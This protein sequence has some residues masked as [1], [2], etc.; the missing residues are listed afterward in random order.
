MKNLF[1]EALLGTVD[2]CIASL[3]RFRSQLF[4]LKLAEQP[5][6]D[7][8]PAKDQLLSTQEIAQYLNC[9]LRTVRRLR[10]E[11]IIP[12]VKINGKW[13]CKLE[14]LHQAVENNPSIS[15]H[16]APPYKPEKKG[17]LLFN[18]SI[19]I[20]S[21]FGNWAAITLKYLWW[22]CIIVVD[23]NS[24]TDS[25]FINKLCQDV[26]NYQDSLKPFKQV[27]AAA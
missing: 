10:E 14:H 3:G 18:H 27:S 19:S 22:K 5:F 11:G 8:D 7:V 4:S 26:I 13:F 9:S 16:D 12:V 23:K 15:K 20:R 6:V 24:V 2:V 21:M 1:K 17:Q 25:A